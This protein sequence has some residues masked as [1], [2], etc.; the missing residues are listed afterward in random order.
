MK[1]SIVINNHNNEKYIRQALDSALSQT[2]QPEKVIIV[3]DGSSDNSKIIL[4]NCN[5]KRLDVVFQTNFG[6]LSAIANG[7]LKSPSEIVFLLDGDDFYEADHAEKILYYW[8]KSPETDIIF[9]RSKALNDFSFELTTEDKNAIE[10]PDFI[11]PIN[12]INSEY[13]F[14]RNQ[15]LAYFCNFYYFGNRTSCLSLK[16][17]H[18]QSLNI[19]CDIFYKEKIRHCAD[20]IILLTSALNSGFKLYAPVDSVFYRIHT[21]QVS[22]LDKNDVAKK[23]IWDILNAK[24]RYLVKK[25]Y[26]YL[27]DCKSMLIDELNSLSGPSSNHIAIYNLAIKS[28]DSSSDHHLKIID[29][30][31]NEIKYLN[32]NLIESNKK[33]ESMKGS[34]C[35]KITSPVR[36]IHEAFQKK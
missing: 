10:Q 12:D 20:L 24:I 5:D 9:C 35:W 3:D 15:L 16:K 33:I 4:E 34:L 28:L 27:S 21:S 18:F 29:Q 31:I 6:Q 8:N 13:K 23:V 25:D 26:A 36:F 32:K 30:C 14:G 22:C 11:G 19:K 7:I 17:S 1:Y 2:V